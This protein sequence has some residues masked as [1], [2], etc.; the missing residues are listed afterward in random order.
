MNRNWLSKNIIERMCVFGQRHRTTNYLES[1]HFMLNGEVGKKACNLHQ[2]LN[3]LVSDA[4][5]QKVRSLQVKNKINL[6]KRDNI[7]IE[8][9]RLI[10][11]AQMQLINGDISV[12][13]FL[14]KLRW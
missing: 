7:Y 6:K 9:D 12:G 3:I 14:E 5:Y 10:Q 13:H 11:N 1:W 2:L 4:S 8:R